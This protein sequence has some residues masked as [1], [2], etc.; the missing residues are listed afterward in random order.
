[1]DVIY[2]VV[3]GTLEGNFNIGIELFA[4]RLVLRRFLVRIVLAIGTIDIVIR[5]VRGNITLCR[6]REF[7]RVLEAL[8][9]CGGFEGPSF[10]LL[11]A[12]SAF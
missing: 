3:Y 5:G 12:E 11:E 2:P 10:I 6:A 1:M 4:I 9:R 8:S 7:V